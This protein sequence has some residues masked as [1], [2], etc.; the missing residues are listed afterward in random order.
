MKMS[1]NKQSTQSQ[2]SIYILHSETLFHGDSVTDTNKLS[3]LNYV[4]GKR[5]NMLDSSLLDV[6]LVCLNSS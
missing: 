6:W 2:D 3:E 5:H 4:N 1:S